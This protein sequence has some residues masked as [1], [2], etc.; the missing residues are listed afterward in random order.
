MSSATLAIPIDAPIEAVFEFLADPVYLP[1]WAIHT[2]LSARDEQNG[3]WLIETP[4]GPSRYHVTASAIHGVVDH[5]FV[6]A[7][8]NRFEIFSRLAPTPDGCVYV[9][10]VSKPQQLAQ[11]AF[12]ARMESLQEELAELKR[13]L[14]QFHGASGPSSAWET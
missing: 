12:H 5:V 11:E 14:E 6:D 8:E 7:M 13:L 1:Q 10:V 9:L 4:N 2:V 3:S